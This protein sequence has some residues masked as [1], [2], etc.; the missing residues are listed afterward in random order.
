MCGKLH[1][2]DLKYPIFREKGLSCKM[3]LRGCV[4]VAEL[5]GAKPRNNGPEG[6]L[7]K[8]L[9]GSEKICHLELEFIRGVF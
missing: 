6:S 9:T 4:R 1:S 7:F 5:S 2:A 8:I 3:L